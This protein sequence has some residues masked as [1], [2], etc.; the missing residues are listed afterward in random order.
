LNNFRQLVRAV[1]KSHGELITLLQSVPAE[2]FSKDR[3]LRSDGEKVTIACIL[4]VEL[5]DERVHHR[6]IVKFG[7]S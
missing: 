6:Q 3:G 5:D 7:G 4:Q 1:K 2:E